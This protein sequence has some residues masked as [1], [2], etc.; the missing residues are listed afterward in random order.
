MLRDPQSGSN[1]TPHLV[2]AHNIVGDT[3]AYAKLLDSIADRRAFGL[4]HAAHRGMNA[5]RG[6]AADMLEEYSRALAAS[7]SQDLFDLMGRHWPM[8]PLDLACSAALALPI[9]PF[10]VPTTCP[11]LHDR[12]VLW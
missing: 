3:Q 1:D 9:T 11:C 8:P 6:D 7:F 4:L 5:T 2:I 10:C 12:Y